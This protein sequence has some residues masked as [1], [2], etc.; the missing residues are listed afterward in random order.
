MDLASM[1]DR[2]DFFS[3]FFTTVEKYYKEA[4]DTDIIFSFANNRKNCNMVIK[5]KLSAASSI[6]ISKRA[7]E[8]FYSEWNIR[9]S[10]L[11][12]CIAKIY[13]FFTTRTGSVF[14]QFRFV[15]MPELENHRDVII[16]PNNRS[17]RIFDYS[18][19]I[20]GCIIKDGFTDKFFKNQIDF[21]E[22]YKY[23]FILPMLSF[24]EDW[25]QEPIMHGHPLARITNEKVYQ[26]ALHDAIDDMSIL[27]KDTLEYSN[28]DE[29]ISRL[30]QQIVQM[31]DIAKEKKK[32]Q[33]DKETHKIV[34]FA[35]RE[36]ILFNQQIPTV[37]SHGDFQSGNI[38]VDR[39]HKV[40][41][42]DWET[43][44][45]RSIWYDASVL[46]YSLRRNN[47]WKE[48]MEIEAPLHMKRCDINY[49]NYS[50]D[51]YRAIKG[52]ILL[53]DLCFY[54]EDMLELPEYWG[55][56]L[57]DAFIKRIVSIEKIKNSA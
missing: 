47:G 9:N 24:G 22:N 7:R 23:D 57:Y 40:W 19:N 33:C 32:I 4:L 46:Q 37:M 44:G 51:Q 18:K 16:A 34:E 5:P 21:R 8:F 45:R 35:V 12:N 42:Y 31:L 6:Y 41:I 56:E 2:E 13:I 29:Y 39:E 17:I 30:K 15:M 52:I 55:A 48:L 10:L 53:E 38:W 50:P 28:C 11:K 43:A 3:F 49:S 1:L 26:K 20:V 25:F 14:S 54:L 27:A 36:A